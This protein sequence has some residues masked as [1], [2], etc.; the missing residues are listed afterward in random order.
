[1]NYKRGDTITYSGGL[2]RTYFIVHVSNGDNLGL[3]GTIYYNVHP[4][5]PVA[6]IGY[7]V[8]STYVKFSVKKLLLEKV[9]EF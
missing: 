9:Y 4:Q 1:M 7:P 6:N 8:E 5:S 2:N 3:E